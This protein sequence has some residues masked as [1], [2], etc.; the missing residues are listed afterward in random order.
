MGTLKNIEKFVVAEFEELKRYGIRC[1]ARFVVHD[2]NEAL[3][4]VMLAPEVKGTE[5][6][7]TPRELADADIPEFIAA[8]SELYRK[9]LKYY[10]DRREA[11]QPLLRDITASDQYIYARDAA[12]KGTLTLIDPDPVIGRELGDYLAFVSAG[13]EA[14]E[15]VIQSIESYHESVTDKDLA[16]LLKVHAEFD[17]YYNWARK[18]EG[19]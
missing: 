6:N 11:H 18:D 8:T 5:L 13:K 4:L 2:V 3:H 7:E 9:L 19:I 1:D 16:P 12:G 17:K 14:L 15:G 10:D